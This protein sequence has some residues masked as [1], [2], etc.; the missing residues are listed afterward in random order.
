MIFM[1]PTQITDGTKRLNSYHQNWKQ[2][3]PFVDPHWQQAGVDYHVLRFGVI[4]L[5][6]DQKNT[7]DNTS[8]TPVPIDS[9]FF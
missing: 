8:F 3:K 2:F 9:N 7:I 1:L 6:K 5:P 4:E